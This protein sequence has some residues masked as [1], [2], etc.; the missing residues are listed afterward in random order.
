MVRVLPPGDTHEDRKVAIACLLLESAMSQRQIMKITNLHEIGVRRYLF[1]L[2]HEK[3]ITRSKK[4]GIWVY[5]HL[6]IPPETAVITTSVSRKNPGRSCGLSHRKKWME[7][8]K[9]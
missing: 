9:A 2:I 3:K 1:E 6:H 8:N 7:L 5:H 4:E